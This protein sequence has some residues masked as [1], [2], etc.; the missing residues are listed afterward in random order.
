MTRPVKQAWSGGCKL[1]LSQLGHRPAKETIPVELRLTEVSQDVM[2]CVMTAAMRWVMLSTP[3]VRSNAGHVLS[4][5]RL[6]Q[7]SN[8]LRIYVV[9]ANCPHRVDPAPVVKP[10]GL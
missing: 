4:V 8:A 2:F 7:D 1:K 6:G 10:N 9:A 3:E 5:P